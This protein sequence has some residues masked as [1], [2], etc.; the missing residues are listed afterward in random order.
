MAFAASERRPCTHFAAAFLLS[1]LG[2]TP[3]ADRVL[4]VRAWKALDP[5][6][7]RAVNI[8]NRDDPW[9]GPAAVAVRF[10]S[11][12]EAYRPNAP[13]PLLHPDAWYFVQRWIGLATP[14]PSGHCYLVHGDGG[15]GGVVHDSSETRGHRAVRMDRWVPPGAAYQIVRL[16]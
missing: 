10:G 8:E 3:T 14:C 1:R 12:V 13:L 4:D 15:G 9:S 6:L 2:L 7:F 5:P 16:P 11:A